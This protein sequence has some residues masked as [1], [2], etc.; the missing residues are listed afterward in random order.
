M[1]GGLGNQLFQLAHAITLSIENQAHIRL[2][3]PVR[4]RAFNLEWL[5]LEKGQTYRFTHFNGGLQTEL[6]SCACTIVD[7]YRE[8][9]FISEPKKKWSKNTQVHGYFQSEIF[10]S[11]ESMLVRDYFKS[12]LILRTNF[13]SQNVRQIT[14]HARFGD[15]ARN[16][17][18]RRFHGVIDDNYV[19]NAL[20]NLGYASE[21]YA[22]QIV[23]D[24]KSCLNTEIPLSSNLATRL[25]S[26]TS[27]LEDFRILVES[28]SLVISN[29]TFS[30]WGAYLSR[31]RVVAPKAWFAGEY[32]TIDLTNFIY[33]SKWE[34]LV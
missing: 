27:A 11:N 34:V 7:L 22:F 25:V 21:D 16:R 4:G 13:Q 6:L 9:S 20:I 15:M 2:L 32:K 33:P 23:T 8:P 12:K 18:A 5:G 24:D 26:S 1:A 3:A 14:L 17:K 10:F 19:L 28:D 31:A 29:S 30:W